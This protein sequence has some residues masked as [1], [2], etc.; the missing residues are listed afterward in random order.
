[1][2]AYEYGNEAALARF[3]DRV[4]P[5]DDFAPPL[6]YAAPRSYRRVEALRAASAFPEIDC[7]RNLLPARLIAAAERRAMVIGLSAD[8]VLISADAITEDAYLA[9]FAASL[10]VVCEPL[11]NVSRDDC[12]L[13][14]EQLIQ[15]A[16]AGLLPLRDGEGITWIIAPRGRTARRLA[17]RSEPRPAWLRSFGLTSSERLSRF[18]AQ[19]T[20]AALGARAT[21]GLWL[22]QPHLS[23]APHRRTWPKALVLGTLAAALFAA[24]PGAAI[25]AISTVLCVAFVAAAAL[26]LSAAAFADEALAQARVADDRLPIYTIICPLYGEAAVVEDLVAHIRAL[27]YPREKLDVKF[28]LEAD[29]N[30]T[31]RVIVA[32]DLGAPFEIVTVPEAGPRT[33]PKA[34]NAALP[35]A[36]GSFTVIY[37]AED[38]PEPGQLRQAFNAFLAGGNRL[39]CVQARLTIDNTA[40]GWLARIFTAEYAGQFDVVLPGL[41]AMHLPILLGGSSNHFRTAVLRQIGGW[42]PYNV[43]EDADLGIR[44]CRFGFRTALV[45][46]STYE[47]AP[48]QIGP[49]LRQRTRW[50]K[51]WMQTCLVQMRS[52]P[53]LLSDLG[54]AGALA[55]ML[56]IGGNVLAALA[57]PVVLASF[58]YMMLTQPARSNPNEISALAILFTTTFL[59]GYIASVVP[60]VI[61]LRRR[62]LLRNA[63]VIVLVPLHW[64]LLSLAAW[65]ALYQLIRDPHRWEKTEHGLARTSRAPG[66]DLP[67][68]DDL[69]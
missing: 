41:A 29:D 4:W 37:D 42:D 40:D 51:G 14:D 36:R 23:N 50:F 43:T 28:V 54:L 33:K 67:G 66:S 26:R 57:H 68:S 31:W 22:A 1:V 9:A 59:S 10:G 25:A 20:G 18:V 47:E 17:D 3:E 62:G 39:A 49:W 12:P 64:L 46:S 32:L 7:I 30:E 34:L 38:R 55:T 6:A 52:P 8:R 48:A 58:S 27:D 11:D 45:E 21:E 53:R 35:F 15:A 16:A 44:L 65:R 63:W 2:V 24:A 5:D 13:D 60:C 69:E 56:V 61:G 19:H